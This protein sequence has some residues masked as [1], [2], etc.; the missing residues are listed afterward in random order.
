MSKGL[1][2]A[3]WLAPTYVRVAVP[4]PVEYRSQ[5][6]GA[7]SI[8]RHGRQLLV[9]MSHEQYEFTQQEARNIGMPFATFVRFM[10]VEMARVLYKERTGEDCN[11][12]R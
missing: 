8:A 3:T 10:A 9:R 2:E 12:E 11:V 4:Q 5:H 1:S 6:Y 7:E